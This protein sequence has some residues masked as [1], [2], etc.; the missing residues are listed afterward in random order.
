MRRLERVRKI[1]GMMD[2]SFSVPFTRI[3]FGWD[4]LIGLVPVVGDATTSIAG[5]W[6]I[7]EAF[8]LR[9][10]WGVLLRMLFNFFL[11]STIG[12]IPIFGD[13]FDVYWKSNRRNAELLATFL[14]RR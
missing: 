13:F 14:Q 4:S 8:R 10:S 2:D 1:A 7:V 9:A 12:L 5:L 6:L 3:R 11:D